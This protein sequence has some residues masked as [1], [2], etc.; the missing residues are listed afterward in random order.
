VTATLMSPKW[1]GRLGRMRSRRRKLY[2]LARGQ[3]QP[4]PE[5][6]QQPPGRGPSGQDHARNRYER[7]A[8]PAPLPPSAEAAEV[9]EGPREGGTGSLDGWAMLRYPALASC[10]AL[11]CLVIAETS[12]AVPHAISSPR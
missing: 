2:P 6:P 11:R 8:V 5:R 9:H 3:R 10:L 4:D 12:D 7:G 1:M